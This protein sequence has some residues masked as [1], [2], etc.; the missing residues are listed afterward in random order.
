MPKLFKTLSGICL[1]CAGGALLLM[2]AIG[3]ANILARSLGTPFKGTYELMGYC[4]AIAGSLALATTQLEKGHI[5]IGLLA[6]KLPQRWSRFG[7]RLGTGCAG[8]LFGLI[9]WQCIGFG[10]SLWQNG[11]VS[12]TLRINYALFPYVVGGGT[13]FLAVVLLWQSLKPD[14]KP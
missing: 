6:D 13:G 2:V 12:E 7:D 1:Y 14:R 3:C 4:G 11:E 10:F 9:S 5:S 8:I